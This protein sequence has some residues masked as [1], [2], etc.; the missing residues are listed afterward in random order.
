M[1]SGIVEEVGVVLAVEDT[2]DGRRLKI[3]AEGI[4][5]DAKL[6]ESISVSGT[7]LT[8]TDFAADGEKG[9][10]FAAEAINETLRRTRLGELQVGSRVNL[11]KAL[12]VSDRLG[13]HIVTGH[14]DTVGEVASIKEDGFSWEITFRAERAFAPY[15]VEKGSVAVEGVSLTVASC[16]TP[17]KA[18]DEFTFT[19]ALIPHTLA[20]T[21][22]GELKVGS[23]VNL[24]TDIIA[25]YVIRLTQLN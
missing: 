16:S 14:I 23:R 2:G 10:W 17:S 18:D 3:G 21:T 8:V 20:V 6:G 5:S 25:R 7:C 13:G 22:L 12:K 19:V 4:L 24:E 15:F 9:R 1:F 11:E